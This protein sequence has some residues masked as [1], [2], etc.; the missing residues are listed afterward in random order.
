V[1][2]DIVEDWPPNIDAI[3]AVLPVSESN[4]FAYGGV[5]YSPGGGNLPSWLVEHE[6]VHFE[7]QERYGLRAWWKRFLNDEEFRLDQEL[8]AHRVEYR[9]FCQTNRD[10][11][12][13][14]RFLMLLSRRLAAPMYGGLISAGEARRRIQ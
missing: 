14:S 2:V 13:Q 3:R 8:P 1:T 9:V 10:R 5:I 4:I 6:K 12:H 11:N 7:Q